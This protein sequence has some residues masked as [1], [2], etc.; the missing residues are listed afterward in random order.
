MSN[1]GPARDHLRGGG[2]CRQAAASGG[3]E[4][5]PYAQYRNP[6]TYTFIYGGDP[7]SP[8][9]VW[10]R[11]NIGTSETHLLYY[12]TRPLC[13]PFTQEC[14]G[15]TQVLSR[16]ESAPA[17]NLPHQFQYD[18]GA[19]SG[20]A[21]LTRVTFPRGGYLRWV[22]QTYTYPNGR[23]FREVVQR[24]LAAD[25]GGP[26]RAF[27]LFDYYPG[28]AYHISGEVEDVTAQARK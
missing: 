23:S 4:E 28:A 10:I 14:Y 24:Y 22:H 27:V 21:E 16:V 3:I 6:Y 18:S 25:A 12:E 20:P 1:A 2:S 17:Y 5:T 13:S 7:Q 8:R 15:N 26:E 9:L 11:N 19:G